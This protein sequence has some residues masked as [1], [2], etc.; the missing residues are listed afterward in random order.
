[1]LRNLFISLNYKEELHFRNQYS[2][3]TNSS[4][5]KETEQSRLL[6]GRASSWRFLSKGRPGAVSAVAPADP[7][8]PITAV[9]CF[10][11]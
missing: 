10:A 8:S 3:F 2:E 11:L 5:G 6:R 9:W 7:S 4:R 1:M